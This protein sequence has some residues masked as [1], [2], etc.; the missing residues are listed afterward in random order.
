MDSPTNQKIAVLTEIRQVFSD[1]RRSNRGG[2]GR[3]YPKALRMLAVSALK[4]GVS[5]S[6]VSEAA[7]VTSE[8]LR[9]WRR[10]APEQGAFAASQIVRP[11]EL[12]LLE[13]REPLPAPPPASA[14]KDITPPSRRGP[15]ARI[16][17]RS[18]VRMSL[19]VS[20]LS[21]RLISL[22]MECASS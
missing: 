2:K 13:S 21:E 14:V 19:P 4:Q 18:G 17:L 12:T 8:S 5:P 16:K 11:V 15:I 10:L 7:G 3:G 6:E 9:N 1:F 22:L 20:A